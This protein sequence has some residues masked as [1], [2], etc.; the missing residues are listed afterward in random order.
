M[1]QRSLKHVSFKVFVPYIIYAT[2]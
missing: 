1:S 2:T